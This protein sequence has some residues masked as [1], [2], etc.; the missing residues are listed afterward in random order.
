MLVLIMRHAERIR[1]EDTPD[2][3]LPLT[4]TGAQSAT[5]AAVQ[6]GERLGPNRQLGLIC[7]SPSLHAVQSAEI[8]RDQLVTPPVR[9]A[10][11]LAPEGA[12]DDVIDLI[13]KSPEE[14]PL[15]LVG[16]LPQLGLLVTH[17]TG[18]QVAISRG[19]ICCINFD[20]SR[21]AGEVLWQIGG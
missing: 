1:S 18:Q 2:A 3:E 14:A 6:L 5:N 11:A 7:S 4:A 13:A 19:S 10:T 16:H 15:L 17:L 9:T 21:A 12:L 20:A 8:M